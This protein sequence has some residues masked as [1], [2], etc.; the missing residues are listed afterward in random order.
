MNK[1]ECDIL[2]AL[3]RGGFANQRELAE[4]AGCSLGSVNKALKTLEAEQIID[5]KFEITSKAKRL[6]CQNKPQRAVILAA[7]Y[8]TRMAPI[9][10]DTPKGLLEAHGEKLIERTLKQLHFAGIN[11]IY[12]VVGYMKEKF[13]YLIDK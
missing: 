8:G 2:V 4:A 13:E 11:E 10:T 7:G 1:I 9:N 5:S 6:L 12:I 3:Y